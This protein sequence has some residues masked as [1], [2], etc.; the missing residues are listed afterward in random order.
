MIKTV[1]SFNETESTEITPVTWENRMVIHKEAINVLFQKHF[2][3][4]FETFNISNHQIA[5]TCCCDV[6]C[7]D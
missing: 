1:L 6:S 5:R 2:T 7:K 3:S 4:V